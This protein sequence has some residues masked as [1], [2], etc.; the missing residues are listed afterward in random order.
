MPNYD[1]IKESTNT[2]YLDFSNLYGWSFSKSVSYNGFEY[3]E[4]LS[5]CTPS[6]IINYEKTEVLVIH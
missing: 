5:R 4:D 3:V 1:E 2:P 6:F